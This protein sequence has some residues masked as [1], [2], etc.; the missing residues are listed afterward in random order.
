M[1]L[2]IRLL[3]QTRD[4]QKGPD[5]QQ[6]NQQHHPKTGINSTQP[7]LHNQ[8]HPITKLQKFG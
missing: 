8:L 5:R 7:T 3:W 4:A 1:Q 2:C 6:A